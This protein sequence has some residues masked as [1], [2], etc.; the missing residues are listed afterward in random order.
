[1]NKKNQK[2][3][4]P[5]G[6]IVLRKT[7][8]ISYPYTPLTRRSLLKAGAAAAVFASL[9]SL[10]CVAG[11]YSKEVMSE[12]DP[13]IYNDSE[14]DAIPASQVITKGK[15][16]S[17]KKPNVII[18][19]TDD[20]GYGDLSCYGSRAIQTPNIDRLS[21]EGMRFT[22]FYSSNALCSPSRAG[23]LTGR[24]AH[25]VGPSYP[26][27]V[28]KG[29]IIY[30][31]MRKLGL[32]IS[33]FGGLDLQGDAPLANG[34]PLSEITI[35]E[36]LKIAGYTTACIGK[37]HLGDF[38]KQPKYLPRKHGFDY[39]T[40]FQGAN[41]TWPVAYWRNETEI[42]KDVGFDQEPYT[43]IFIKEAIEFIERSKDK[44]F[45]LYLSHK[46]P[47]QPCLPSNKFAGSSKAG[48]HGDVIQEVDWGVGEI[49]E[50][51]KRNGL[52]KNTVIFFTSDNGP[53]YDGSPGGLR[54]RKGQSYEG[55]FRVP[56]IAWWPGKISAG[57]ICR[58]PSMN[59]DF[60]P[61]I[62]ALAG[63][64][65]PSD[66]VID[67]KNILNLLT[68][69]EK[70]SPHEELFFFHDNEI[71]GIRVGRWKYFRYIH[72]YTFPIPLDKPNN[73]IG[74]TAGANKFTFVKKDT[75][76]KISYNELGKWPLLYDM[77]YD[78]GE[79]YNVID[80]YPNVARKLHNLLVKW[81][82][83]FYKNPRGWVKK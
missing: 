8:D 77:E 56:M 24:Y 69:K 52:N 73:F 41:D 76:E 48:P 1:M 54:G 42:E 49:L 35:A 27:E 32:W 34:L 12:I 70:K 23:L 59:I 74:T 75:G 82:K 6:E 14:R 28:T 78:P 38:T 66:R 2:K 33:F 67:G 47:H 79:N 36:A 22:D 25:R 64:K 3:Y 72:H 37:W 81:E 57:T 30:K 10:G 53:W 26:I 39:Y 17:G 45:F 71:E 29:G 43:G 9:G 50:C 46:D 16:F 18:I 83:E 15:G 68:G 31:M 80:K 7:M 55:G 58:E 60:F 61:T 44:P 62:L 19:L 40:G 51:L 5:E 65:G 4:I 21:R 63:L 13:D 11:Y 20:Q